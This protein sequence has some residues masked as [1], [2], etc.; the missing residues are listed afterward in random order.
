MAKKY[1]GF[2]VSE[3]HWD[4]AWYLPFEG[5]RYRLVGT[6]DKLLRI[7]EEKPNYKF[8][9]DGQTVVVEDYLQIRP[10][11]EKEIKKFVEKK[12]L[13]LGPW[14][15]LPDEYLISAE[16]HVRNLLV[17]HRIAG[18]YGHVMKA[19]YMPDPFGHISQMPQILRG[20]D[21]D[22]FLFMR[23]MGD[24]GEELGVEFKWVASDG[25][26][27][28]YAIHLP[29]G[30][31][32][33]AG[34][35]VK[36]GALVDSKDVDYEGALKRVLD[37]VKLHEDMGLH[38]KCIILCN[39]VDH[40]PAQP[41]VPELIEYVNENQDVV[42]LVH[43]SFEDYIDAVRAENPRL[44]EWQGELH[45]GRYQPLL[46][47][48]YSSRMYLKQSNHACSVLLEKF[49]EPLCC[50][51]ALE[52]EEYPADYIYYA[53]RELLKN[54]PHDDICGCS[55]DET[56]QD[57]VERFRHVRQVGIILRDE[58][59]EALQEKIDT[60]SGEGAPFVVFNMAPNAQSAVVSGRVWV[61]AKLARGELAIVDAEG[62][63][64]L[65]RVVKLHEQE[66]HRAWRMWGRETK[67][68][69][70]F[71]SGRKAE[72]EIE[73]LAEDLPAFGYKVYY[74]VPAEKVALKDEGVR[75]RGYTMENEFYKVKVNANGTVDITD[76]ETGA[77]F[78][79]CNL[80]EDTEDKGDGY[81]YSPCEN[82]QT[83]T[84]RDVK[85]KIRVIEA[86]PYRA[87]MRVDFEMVIPAGLTADRKAR[88]K[89]VVRVPVSTE[90]SLT[91]GVKRVDFRTSIDN[92]AKDHRMRAVFPTGIKTDS[93]YASS[94]FDVIKRS[95][96]LPKGRNWIQKPVPTHHMD[97]FV[98]VSD[99]KMG[100]A[101]FNRGMPEY[102]AR[103][104]G[105]GVV[106][107]QTLFRAVG[108]LSKGDLVTRPYNVGP[109]VPAPEGQMQGV[110][111]FEYAVMPH[112]G[113][114]VDGNV[115][116]LAEAYVSQPVM[117]S[118]WRHGGELPP[119]ASFCEVEPEELVVTAFKRAEDRDSVIVRFY[120]A[121]L[122]TV[123]GHVRFY[124]ALAEA[125]L[126]KLSE[127][128]VEKL[129]VEDGNSV[130]IQVK[131]KKIVS[132]EF[133]VK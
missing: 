124:K 106:L 118:T 24:E 51:A 74:V 58:A 108:W 85:G 116:R 9:F 70:K 18:H 89:R 120:N 25:E 121:G 10:Y 102:E 56:H 78:R 65:G 13:Y 82:S 49:V 52:G 100:F 29:G 111:T 91:K 67:D 34:W 32:S 132:V 22:S 80:I 26:S 33:L 40:L 112:K 60:E 77:V 28:V 107:Y 63:P 36:P 55:V 39:G 96:Q 92:R 20:F 68:D 129:A 48:V 27:W 93:V 123:E 109:E 5:F 105:R 76:K 90:I 6:F 62:K 11:R 44:K 113:D 84:A 115:A 131:P 87:K 37:V 64:A 7:M 4:R 31:G 99:G 101:L 57:M 2:V 97:A 8:V 128:R 119:V 98:D 61:D 45:G 30:Y 46:S 69:E 79:G 1:K 103:P 94:K 66:I 42:E 122:K 86:G 125:H 71:P 110:Y 133:V 75:V 72:L 19:G 3:T 17:G 35:G 47:G 127:E 23:G 41:V 50:V 38:T 126:V 73:L 114:Y 14:Y 15:I 43:A 54:H 53:W 117:V 16:S 83:I 81:D 104:T 12:Q 88:Q 59:L 130:S 21:L 95:L